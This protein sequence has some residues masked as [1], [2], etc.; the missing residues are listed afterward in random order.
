MKS[1]SS[2]THTCNSIRSW[3]HQMLRFMDSSQCSLLCCRVGV[4][5][6]SINKFSTIEK[7]L[8]WCI[9]IR[10]SKG[11]LLCVHVV[12]EWCWRRHKNTRG[13]DIWGRPCGHTNSWAGH[14]V[15]DPILH[16]EPK[17]PRNSG[18]E[19]YHSHSS[20]CRWPAWKPRVINPGLSL[21]T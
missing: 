18:T 1:P 5:S 4:S 13:L 10:Y 3:Q 2:R 14:R 15:H 17:I 20:Y 12:V 21:S 7:L 11:G 8:E 6:L 16:H 9:L 19:G